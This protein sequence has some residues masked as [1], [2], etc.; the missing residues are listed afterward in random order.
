MIDLDNSI[1]NNMNTGGQ[2]VECFYLRCDQC[3]RTGCTCSCHIRRSD[4]YQR[5]T[6]KNKNSK[7]IFMNTDNDNDPKPLR[8]RP[9]RKNKE[10]VT[11]K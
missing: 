9:S 5:F 6:F 8:G 2:T 7:P 4:F 1:I 3:K 11:K 10:N